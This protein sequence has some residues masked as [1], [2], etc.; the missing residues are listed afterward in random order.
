ME[1]EPTVAEL[2]QEI[3]RLHNEL[4]QAVSEKI[5]SAKYG[6]G[7]LE[8]K[9]CLLLKCEEL[10][11]SYENA[12]H[13]LEITQQA[14]AKFQT[15]HRVTTISGIEQEESLLSE[16]A[17]RETSL[18]STIIDLENEQ[19]QLRM[20]L[21]RV[22]EERDRIIQDNNDINK[23]KDK[24][25]AERKE[26]RAELRDFKFR[27]TRLNT[28]YS[29]LEEENITLQKQ[30]SLLK[31]SQVE[32]EGAKHENRRLQEDV[33]VL[34]NQVE[35]LIKIKAIIEK[36]LEEALES[37]QMEREAKF[38]M[39][40]ELDHR[41]NNE[42][43]F[44]LNNLAFSLRGMT[45]DHPMGSDEEDELPSLQTIEADLKMDLASPDNKQVD[46]FS[47][48]HLNEI[49]K[50]EKQLEL[51]E[52][53][54]TSLVQKF[55]EAQASSDHNHKLLENI[56]A[57]ITKL[58]AY[59]SS[60][61]SLTKKA[62]EKINSAKEDSEQKLDPVI[63]QNVQW[64]ILV[65]QEAAKIQADLDELIKN[66]DNPDT[67]FQLKTEITELKNKVLAAQ[68]K[69]LELESNVHYFTSQVESIF[70]TAQNSFLSVT[71]DLAQLYHHLCAVNG[72]TPSLVILDHEKH[73][74][75]SENISDEVKQETS[76]VGSQVKSEA[77]IQ[78]LQKISEV[79]SIIKHSETIL[80]Q[81]K[82]I[83]TAI[84]TTIDNTKNKPRNAPFE[85]ASH[86][87]N[88]EVN[89]LTEQIIRLKSLLSTKREQI[90]TLRT[91][92]KS[93]KKTAEDA[94]NNLKSKYDTEK[95]VVSETMMK[96]RNELRVLKEEQATF[97]SLRA[98]FAARCEEYATQVDELK[99]QL[100][101]AEEE[102]KTLNQLLR[103]AVQQKIHLNQRLEDFELDREIRNAR[104]PPANKQRPRRDYL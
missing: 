90:A 91:V 88:E 84:S 66:L 85:A 59:I 78:D 45:E 24:L 5:Q 71:D 6:L 75:G 39:K 100:A 64:F 98:M 38:A 4:D 25:E 57:R 40:K 65:E 22:Q 73:G 61:D 28:E 26:L 34:Q 32:F 87:N 94:L 11:T 36:K 104:R 17:A 99:H 53:E 102:K 47:E 72:E 31:S 67:N 33:L 18:N 30:V 15:N 101:A 82:H 43:I 86:Q 48:I 3:D 62:Q 2:K 37:L 14:L 52:T 49:K 10:E 81:V 12:K 44:N 70:S 51:V 27:E 20:E 23:E 83:R 19:R 16:S 35:D 56:V 97:S 8:E 63:L 1:T 69:S 96:M 80:D 13:D 21:E 9:Q 93:N 103:L 95:S 77:I 79:S 58:D 50:L 29:E 60:L 76:T 41:L 7:L 89:E 46:L 54:K 92:L 68:Q 42:S 74:E 55:K